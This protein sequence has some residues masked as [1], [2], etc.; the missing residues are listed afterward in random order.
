[1]TTNV[2]FS[3][4]ARSA[5]GASVLLLMPA[6]ASAS[7]Q[8]D[9]I[10]V[11]SGSAMEQ[12]QRQTTAQLDRRLSHGAPLRTDT[13]NTIVQ[14]TFTRGDDGKPDNVQFYNREGSWQ[15]RSIAKRAVKSLDNL[16]LVPIAT[17]EE[18]NFLA[19]IIFAN[20]ERSLD[21][22][23]ERLD[24]MESARLASAGPQAKY[25]ALGY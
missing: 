20:D 9:D 2:N 8:G 4:L 1:M 3:V 24:K 12:W 5:L 16:D 7:D 6:M 13:R 22:L 23:R 17:S 21:M 18:P 10:V 14:I 25:L 11:S 15:E 19:S